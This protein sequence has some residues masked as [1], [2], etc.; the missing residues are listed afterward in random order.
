MTLTEAFRSQAASCAALGSPFMARLMAVLTE[1]LAPDHGAVSKRLFGW[2]GDVSSS[3]A[4]LP[5]RLAGGL[6]ALALGGHA[7]LRA[8]YPPQDGPL[9]NAVSAAMESEAAFLLDWIECPPQTNE[10]RRATVLRAVGQWLVA[11]HGLPLEL[12]ELGA[13]AGLNLNW[14][15]YGLVAGG[16]AFGPAEPALTLVPDWSGPLPPDVEPA[17]ASRRG[18]DRAPV[19]DALRLRAYTWPDQPDRMA[20]LDAALRL[21]PV[22]VDRADAADW[23]EGLAPQAEGTARL[24]CHTIAWQYFPEATRTRARAA[25]ERIGAAATGDAPLAWFGMEADGG[26]GAGLTL[27]LWPGD[28]RLDAGRC[29]FHGRWVEW[30]LA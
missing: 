18:V 7:G 30:R 10:V 22:P 21:P 6:H 27:R 9:W 28:R 8:A 5:L 25:I 4:S 16:A 11:R 1:R 15:R 2:Q 20:R 23:L 14:D 29:D 3:G 12:R 19:R 26:R 17:I 24:V 13:S